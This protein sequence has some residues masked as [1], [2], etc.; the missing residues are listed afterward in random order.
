MS[1]ENENTD[2]EIEVNNISILSNTSKISGATNINQ[3]RITYSVGDDEPPKSIGMF[4][5]LLLHNS[6]L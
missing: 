6:T 2:A 1:S 3:T 4:M 5:Y